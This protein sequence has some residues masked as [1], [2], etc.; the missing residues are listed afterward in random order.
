MSDPTIR[1]TSENTTEIVRALN[2]CIETCMDA[3][4]GYGAAAADVRA[5]DLK[6][7]CQQSAN[8]RGAFVLE[9]QAAIRKLGAF[10]ENEGTFSGA[11]RRDWMTYRRLVEGPDDRVV[12]EGCA[13][14]EKASIR[15]YE[16]AD[17]AALHP[18]PEE[19]RQLVRHQYAA[20]LSA[21]GDL[22]SRLG[23]GA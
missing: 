9:L 12:L 11:V 14:G 17:R 6:H 13:D 7:L 5:P 22:R 2:G 20:I 10:P 1:R 16:A 3:E 15:A 4:K 18:A 23:A 19:I 21:H 8:Q